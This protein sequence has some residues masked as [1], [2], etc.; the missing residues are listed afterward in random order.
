MCNK[1]HSKKSRDNKTTTT[2]A[3]DRRRI[4]EV[5]P[6]LHCSIVG[7]CLSMR[8]LDAQCAAL[9]NKL[10]L[11]KT[12]F[13]R[14]LQSRDEVI[15][16]M[17]LQLGA[18]KDVERKLAL[19]HETIF[20]LRRDSGAADLEKQVSELREEL[21]ITAARAERT[22]AALVEAGKFIEQEMT[23]TGEAM[24]R[25]RVLSEENTAL[26]QELRSALTCHAEE[27]CEAMIE[28]DGIKLCGR[29]I[30]YVGGRGNLVRYYRALVERRGGVFIHHDGGIESSMDL[31]KR[32]V[33]SADAVICPID[34]V[35]HGAC[36]A[37]K[38]TCKQMAKPFI[39]LRSAGLSSLAH[40]MQAIG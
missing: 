20:H 32:A 14:R 35:S 27:P 31:L 12:I 17:R 39:P 8:E 37:I 19:A 28:S 9:A 3:L 1:H 16:E 5:R 30:M 2:T 38:K 36:L 25:I 29:K 13:R 6:C 26:E 18:L 7:T 21:R 23:I 24:E 4:W 22:E 15:A 34:C 11:V 40:G 33:N 10:A